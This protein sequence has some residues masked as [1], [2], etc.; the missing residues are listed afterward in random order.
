MKKIL[1]AVLVL[2]LAISMVLSL[3]GCGGEQKPQLKVY[4]WGD[5]IDPSIIEEF[6]EKYNIDVI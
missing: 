4:N 1:K 2:T 5:Y 3:T 6:E